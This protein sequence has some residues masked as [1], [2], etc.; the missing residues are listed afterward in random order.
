MYSGILKREQIILR[1]NIL[2]KNTPRQFSS[3]KVKILM[4]LIRRAL[5]SL[6][7]PEAH[8]YNRPR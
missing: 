5:L 3:E 1:H 4:R 7:E 6:A 8:K 2:G